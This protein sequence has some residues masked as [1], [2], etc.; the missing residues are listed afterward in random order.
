MK[1][2]KC[3]YSD[4]YWRALRWDPEEEYTQLDNFPE[5]KEWPLG[6]VFELQGFA[7]WRKKGRNNNTEYVSRL[8]LEIYR[9]RGNRK[10]GRGSYY[11]G[12]WRRA[13]KELEVTNRKL[14][15][16]WTPSHLKELL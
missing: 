9:A 1:C 5:A 6:K 4:P 11:E 3:G 10:R 16:F 8:P 2:P 14:K 13:I 7:M 15:E 12:R